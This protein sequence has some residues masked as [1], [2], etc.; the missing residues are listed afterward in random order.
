MAAGRG[1]GPYR[2]VQQQR[3]YRVPFEEIREREGIESFPPG[4]VLE[5]GAFAAHDIVQV[6]ELIELFDKIQELAL[7]AAQLFAVVE[8]EDK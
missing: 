1:Y 8:M 7:S 5:R 4:R 3:G 2:S 6:A